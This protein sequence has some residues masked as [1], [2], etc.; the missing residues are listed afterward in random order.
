MSFKVMFHTVNLTVLLGVLV[1]VVLSREVSDGPQNVLL[2]E[3]VKTLLGFKDEHPRDQISSPYGVGQEAP[4]YMLDLYDRFRNS[5]ISKGHLSGNTV[6]SIHAEIAEVNGEEMFV[7]NLTSIIPS[8]RLLS[9]EIHLY[10][11]KM[12]KARRRRRDLD[13]LMYEI[14][15]HYMSENGKITMRAESF[16][17]QWYDVTDAALSCL[18]ARRDTP[19]L[20]ALKFQV[21]WQNGKIKDVALKKFIRHH[22]MPFLIIYSND[23]QNNELDS[24]ENLAENMHKE[25]KEDSDFVSSNTGSLIDFS[26]RFADDKLNSEIDSNDH[27]QDKTSKSVQ[28]RQKRSIFNNK[29]PEDPADYDNFHRKFNIPQTHP[30]ILQARR[31][32]RHKISDSR[33]IPFPDEDRRKNR[34]NN[35]K[36]RKNK[37]KNRRR[38]NKNSNLLF[39]KEWDRFRGTGTEENQHGDICS[40]RKLILDFADIGWEDK[41]IAPKSFEAHYC[42]GSCPFPLTK[43]LRPS[44]HATIQSMVHAI[45]IHTDVP[46][47][48][49]VPES[50]SSITLLFFDSNRNVVLK[51]YPSMSVKACG[52]R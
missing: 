20:F 19:H 41:I 24:L 18:A 23:T 15:P 45:G 51:N 52:C 13:L 39:P 9:A 48:C 32:S 4:K 35:R 43:K 34:R 38:K 37:R 26:R 29:I 8:E 36:N 31:E 17:W 30:D 44:N 22:S 33:L 7:F 47:P 11:R 42:A 28:R 16:G 21:E 3:A 49:C 25:K 12:K 14:A 6:R 40:K 46:A 2:N 5:Q 1:C 50:L 27:S 10:K